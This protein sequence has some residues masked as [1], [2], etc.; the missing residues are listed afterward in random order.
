MI[1]LNLHVYEGDPRIYKFYTLGDLVEFLKNMQLEN[2]D[3]VWLATKECEFE[4]IVITQHVNNLIDLIKNN[5]F[6][7]LF[8]SPCTLYLQQY[9]SYE[10]AY[11]V[12]LSMR[13]PNPKCYA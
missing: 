8:D 11:T 6:N 3:C 5:F 1:Q 9:E 4:E 13:E 7:L 10:D 12:A 2:F